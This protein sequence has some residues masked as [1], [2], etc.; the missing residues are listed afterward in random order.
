MRI[1]VDKLDILFSKY[2][3]LRDRVCQR[4]GGSTG[5][6]CSHYHGRRKQS[7]RYDEENCMA[8]CWGCHSYLGANP[9]EH[10]EFMIKRLGQERFDML[11]HRANIPQKIDKIAIGLYVRAKINELEAEELK[12]YWD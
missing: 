12:K 6:G 2:I 4:C 8:L 3:R 1:K 7:V 11:T 5:L 9:L 10:T